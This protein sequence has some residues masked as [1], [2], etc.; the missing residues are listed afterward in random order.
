M[1]EKVEMEQKNSVS[2]CPC[3]QNRIGHQSLQSENSSIRLK[4]HTSEVVIKSSQSHLKE[5]GLEKWLFTV[6]TPN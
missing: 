5:V 6:K 4:T 2:L 3:A 1:F